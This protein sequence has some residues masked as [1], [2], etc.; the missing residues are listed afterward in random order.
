MT[1]DIPEDMTELYD[2]DVPRLDLVGKGANGLPLLIAKQADQPG[3]FSPGYLRDLLAKADADEGVTNAADPRETVTMSGSPAA[4][5]ALIHG[6]A[7]RKARAADEASTYEQ[8]VKAK[9]DADDLKQM[10]ANG[11]AMADESYPIADHADLDRAVHAVGRGGDEHNAIRRHIARRAKALGATGEIPDNW[12]SDG[13]LKKADADVGHDTSEVAK[14]MDMT[15]AGME[16]DD[17]IDG[18]D[19]TVLLACPEEEAPGDPNDPGSPAWE[20]IDAATARKWTAIAARLRSALSI[21]ADREILE[22]V[23]ADGDD[24]YAAADLG[25]AGAAVDF[26][27][28]ILAPFAVDEQAEADC[29]ADTVMVG[30]AMAGFDPA[31]LDTV[32]ALG[33][34]RKAGRALST[35][36]E[37][38]LRTALKAIQQILASLPKAPDAPEAAPAAMT[39]ETQPMSESETVEG[40]LAER[41]PTLGTPKEPA[42]AETPAAMG[43]P[44]EVA[45]AHEPVEDPLDHFAKRLTEILAISGPTQY[46]RSEVTD[47]QPIAKATDAEPEASDAERTPAQPVATGITKAEKAPQMP[48]YDAKGNLMGV[49]DPAEL[50][51]LAEPEMPAT[52]TTQDVEPVAA[53]AQAPQPGPAAAAAPEPATAP[54]TDLTPAPAASV[55]TPADATQADDDPVAKAATTTEASPDMLKGTVT[56]LLKA[57]FDDYSAGQA[58]VVKTL[59]E[60]NRALEERNATLEKKFAAVDERLAFIEKQEA[61]PRVFSNG[62]LPPRHM[63]RG[64]DQGAPAD[65]GEAAALRKQ[66]AEAPDANTRD[67]VA[68]RMQALAIAQYGVMRERGTA[69]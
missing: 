49:V 58:D 5:A 2:A 67:E 61:A 35:A 47:G 22:A 18:M 1:D 3:L 40:A 6:A 43:T 7:V 4:I 15:S 29:G 64:Q 65:Q 26:V 50:T 16:M 38:A 34:V 39:K 62:M 45:K 27:I 36:N 66:L 25:D 28:S 51:R 52:A 17:G 14:D 41:V 42:S 11:Q 31:H 21:M 68:S 53:E 32:E 59:E 57:A 24:A 54:P 20:A 46:G 10:A 60:R 13:S 12:A 69:M 63:M 19:P 48:V 33:A 23:S 37:T 55:G 8:L 9:Y 44:G 30:K 56:E